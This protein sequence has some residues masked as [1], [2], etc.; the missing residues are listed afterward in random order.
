MD[1]KLVMS[2]IQIL[3]LVSCGFQAL[4]Y[5]HAHFYLSHSH[6]Y[7]IISKDCYGMGSF[8]TCSGPEGGSRA[9]LHVQYFNI[10]YTYL[11]VS[12]NVPKI[13][14]DGEGVY[15]RGGGGYRRVGNWIRIK[16]E[17]YQNNFT[18]YFCDSSYTMVLY[19]YAFCVLLLLLARP[20]ILMKLCEGQGRR[21]IYA[22]LYFLPIT[23]MIHGACAGLLCKMYLELSLNHIVTFF[24]KILMIF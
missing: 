9:F 14:G 13:P 10:Q 3:N 22:A 7:F 19:Y 11:A 23:A 18:F 8:D 5:H 4:H 6:N 20:I 24:V 2:S 16:E 17:G 1:T 12:F 21:C 15:R